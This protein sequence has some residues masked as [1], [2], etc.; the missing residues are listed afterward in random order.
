MV[1]APAEALSV[2]LGVGEKKKIILLRVF[3]AF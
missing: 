2:A 3:Q 1:F